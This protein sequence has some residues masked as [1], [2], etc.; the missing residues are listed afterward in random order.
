MWRSTAWCRTRTG[1]CWSGPCRHRACRCRRRRRSCRCR[2]R[3][4]PGPGRRRRTIGHC[5]HCR[6][7]CRLPHCR[8]A[9]LQTHCRVRFIDPAPKRRDELD[10][11][12]RRERIAHARSD[13]IGPATRAFDDHIE[14][15]V[16]H[17]R[18]VARTALEP[19]GTRAAVERVVAG[20]ARESV[21][22]CQTLE[23]IRSTPADEM[24]GLAALL[25]AAFL[26][27][28]WTP[29]L[30][31]CSRSVHHPCPSRAPGLR[32]NEACS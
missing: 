27:D 6:A 19:V 10:L 22:A 31:R 12:I 1:P 8:S 21:V 13:R 14:R 26:R 11:G 23:R 20:I 2:R 24:V 7:A 25:D 3:P 18:V 16:D 15:V 28:V 32:R 17:E 29:A 4:S 5:R 30:S 9:H